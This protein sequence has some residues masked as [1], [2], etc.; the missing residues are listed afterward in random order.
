MYKEEHLHPPL[1]FL[2]GFN[3]QENKKHTGERPCAEEEKN[4]RC[5]TPR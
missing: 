3:K 1:F 5:I 2:L 4:D